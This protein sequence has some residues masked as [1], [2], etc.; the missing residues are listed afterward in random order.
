MKVSVITTSYNSGKTIEET[1]QSVANQS[2]TNIEHL[3]ID[4][5]SNDNTLDIVKKYPHL[6]AI[7]EEDKGL[8]D[9][10]NK[11][12]QMASGDIIAILNSD[13]L[14]KSKEVIGSVVKAFENNNSECILTNIE[15]FDS[16]TKKVIRN[17][18]AKKWKLWMFRIGW[19]PPHPGFFAKKS[20]YEKHGTYN[21]KYRISADFDF[22][23]RTL[24]H[25][26]VAYSKIKIISVSM[27][28]G[29]IS[30]SGLKSIILANNEDNQSLKS[31]GY[32]SNIIMIWSKYLLKIVQYF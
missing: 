25:Y 21:I 24:Y 4:G 14:Y 9:A 2:Y 20:V 31:Y 1:I 8:Y 10:M 18:S 6:I 32:F 7:S 5:K 11:G 12:I 17:Y 30:Q 15:I 26:K 3:I 29:G 22:M 19:Q 27:R 16:D 13:D 28:S 23:F